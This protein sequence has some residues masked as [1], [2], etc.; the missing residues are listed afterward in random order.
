MR[1]IAPEILLGR[2]QSYWLRA[3]SLASIYDC[4]DLLKRCARVCANQDGP[5][6]PGVKFC[7]PGW[8]L[9]GHAWLACHGQC[10]V[11]GNANH[12]LPMS[13]GAA[14]KDEGHGDAP[15]GSN[16]VFLHMLTC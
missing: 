16:Y 1:G 4:R 2:G 9:A 11:L 7:E 5:W 3:G 10:T 8:K 6:L 14:G 12:D 15:D 13:V